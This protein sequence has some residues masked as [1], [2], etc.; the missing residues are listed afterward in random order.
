MTCHTD[1]S[2]VTGVCAFAAVLSVG[3]CVGTRATA[4]CLV[5][6]TGERTRSI[7][8]NFP[9]FAASTA[10]TAVCDVVL[11]IDTRTTAHGL[12]F[13]ATQFACPF[14]ANFSGITGIATSTTMFGIVL[15]IHAFLVAYYL[16]CGAG[17]HALTALTHLSCLTGIVT[18]AAVFS[19]ALQ[20]MAS[21]ITYGLSCGARGR[22]SAIATDF[23]GLT[24]VLAFAAVIPIILQIDAYAF[25]VLLSYRAFGFY[26][27][28][29]KTVVV[30]G[31]ILDFCS[32]RKTAFAVFGTYFVLSRNIRRFGG[33]F[34]TPFLALL[35]WTIWYALVVFASF[36]VQAGFP[37]FAFA[38]HTA[39]TF[40]GAFHTRFAAFW[41][42]V[43][44]LAGCTR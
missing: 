18:F 16:S 9:G 5:G 25:A 10:S 8:T 13:G 24:H 12:S 27:F 19:G 20:V 2:G 36:R 17:N 4:I 42:T 29:F 34:P 11:Q 26:A 31:A 37:V 44:A 7:G 28:A 1:L 21:F 15:R 14:V 6:R 39:S 35:A 3:Q 41:Q 33:T 40:L 30:V 23:S 43:A 32:H 22:T 38:P